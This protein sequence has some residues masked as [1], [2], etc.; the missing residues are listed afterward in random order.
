LKGCQA[1]SQCGTEPNMVSESCQMCWDCENKDGALRWGDS[2]ND[3]KN[4]IKITNQEEEK[5]EECICC[6]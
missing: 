4:D 1:C 5:L 2:S 3:N 6:R